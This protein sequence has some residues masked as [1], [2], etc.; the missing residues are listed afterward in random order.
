MLM[1]SLCRL[2]LLLIAV[3][4]T[5]AAARR[6][7]IVILLADDLGYQDVGVYGGPVKTPSIDALAASGTRFT[8]VGVP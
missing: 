7:N 8:E 5:T 6:P 1:A 3:G 2:L 4:A